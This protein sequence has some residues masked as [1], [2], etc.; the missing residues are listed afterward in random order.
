M[1][2]LKVLYFLTLVVVLMRYAQASPVSIVAIMPDEGRFQIVLN[3]LRDQA[4]PGY[5][6]DIIDINKNPTVKTIA[7]QCKAVNA[8]GLVLMDTKAVNVALELQNSDSAFRDLPKFIFMTLW[9]KIV[10]KDLS[11]IAGITFE[12]P[13][14]TLIT[15]F[16]IISQKDFSNVGIFY[17]K[18][19]TPAIEES[20]KLLE[21]EKITL[22]C[23]CVDC[24]QNQKT[25]ANDIL[26]VMNASWEQM[27]V[28]KKVEAFIAPTD[29]FIVN[30]NSLAE[31]WI[32]KIMKKKIPII[33]TIDLLAS[34]KFGV[35][36]FTADPDLIQLGSQ[37][38]NQIVDH[39]ENKTP[40]EKIGFEPT[41]SIKST[42]NMRVADELGWKLK[43]GKLER[44][45]TIIK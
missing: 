30:T 4:G 35:A 25:S 31:F 42:V 6:F 9:A 13:L 44:I 15:N 3:A 39:F 7:D 26:N 14:Y 33:A 29:N 32:G 18:S 37:A 36:V 22:Q 2:P 45:T 38:A 20:K 41:I 19:F 5:H 11:N 23:M 43:K 40:M 27:V 34:E 17:R 12:V 1:K 8:A 28:L 21:K 10:A 24:D 16:R